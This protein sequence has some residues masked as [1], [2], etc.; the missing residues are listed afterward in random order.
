M[1]RKNAT[2]AASGKWESF[3]REYVVDHNGTRA[4]K[5]AGY[6]SGSDAAAA[7]AASRLLK[8]GNVQALIVGF[9]AK[10]GKKY[11]KRLGDIVEESARMGLFDPRLL[12]YPDGSPI[13]PHLWPPEVAACV[14]SYEFA[15]IGRGKKKVVYLSKVRFWDKNTA[16]DRLF[17]HRGLFEKD[18]NQVGKAIARAIIVPAKQA[19]PD[20]RA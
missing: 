10:V 19:A 17:K 9:E 6:K 12:Y 15:S 5:A 1:A 18:N 20:G 13:P 8:N 14:S 2:R 3:A 7:A 4:Y 16:L 11:E